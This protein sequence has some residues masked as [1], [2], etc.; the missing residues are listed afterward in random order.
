MQIYSC[1]S[2]NVVILMH[3]SKC[4]VYQNKPSCKMHNSLVFCVKDICMHLSA[5]PYKKN[6]LKT[7]RKTWVFL[8]ADLVTVTKSSSQ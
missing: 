8:P 5:S 6:V 3:N 2:Y 1:Q 7:G 4:A